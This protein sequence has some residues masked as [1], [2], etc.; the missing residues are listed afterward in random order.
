MGFRKAR[1]PKRIAEARRAA[2]VLRKPS[3]ATAKQAAQ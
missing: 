3:E 1:A 2:R